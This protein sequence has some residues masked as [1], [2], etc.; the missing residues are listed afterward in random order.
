MQLLQKLLLIPLI[1]V[2]AFPSAVGAQVRHAADP[3][4]MAAAIAQHIANRDAD[5][6]AIREAFGRSEVHEAVARAGLDVEQLARLAETM[7][8][9]TLEEAGA[10][11]RQVNQALVGGQSTIVI[12]TTTVLIVLLVVIVLLAID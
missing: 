3:A 4:E 11:A 6:A 8:G 7:S 10:M 1:L 2:T 9:S 5:R 12:S